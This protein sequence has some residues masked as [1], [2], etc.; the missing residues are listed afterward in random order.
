MNRTVL[1]YLRVGRALSADSDHKVVR[2]THL[3]TFRNSR[4]WAYGPPIRHEITGVGEG[5]KSASTAQA[6]RLC[7][8]ELF[9]TVA[10]FFENH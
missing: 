7:H 5:F 2:R 10:I 1:P 4:A 8:Q 9:K 3:C 6:R